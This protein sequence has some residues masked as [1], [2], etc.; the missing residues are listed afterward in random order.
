[1]KLIRNKNNYE[2]MVILSSES[3]NIELERIA[4]NYAQQLKK[5]GASDITFIS[6]GCRNFAYHMNG[7]KQGYFVEMYFKSSPEILPV[8][9]TKLKLDKNIT[10]YLINKNE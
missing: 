9:Q 2:L 3:T 8:Y 5:L 6:R 1:M 4:S 10:R 7:V